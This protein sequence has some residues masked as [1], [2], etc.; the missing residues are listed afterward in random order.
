MEKEQSRNQS[1]DLIKLIAMYGVLILHTTLVFKTENTMV[2]HVLF[3]M[4]GISMPLFFMVSGF[5][6]LNKNRS[7]NYLIKKVFSIILFVLYISLL[8]DIVFLRSAFTLKDWLYDFV[9]AFL[10][11]GRYGIFWYFGAISL[12][13]LSVPLLD[14]IRNRSKMSY[15]LMI[16]GFLL[17]GSVIQDMNITNLFEPVIPQPLRIWYWFPYFMIGG[18]ISDLLEKKHELSNESDSKLSLSCLLA[19]GGGKLM[20]FSLYALYIIYFFWARC[21]VG[22]YGVEY[23]FGSLPCQALSI[24]LFI[25]IVSMQIKNSMIIDSVSKL[26][27]PV[28]ALHMSVLGILNNR[29][30]SSWSVDNS[31]NAA[32]CYLL[33]FIIMTLVGWL[34][35][36]LPYI[37][38]LFKI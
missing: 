16:I 37:N 28:Y 27:L 23:L 35:M 15:I 7:Y 3:S 25:C 29:V 24:V 21:Y 9:G 19:C 36:K 31:W 34:V 5:L 38:K 17:V 13:Y 20:I 11:K 2:G 26:F 1:I 14:K 30:L 18:L 8:L 6:M 4:A 33:V 32:M 10:Q 22:I 12:L